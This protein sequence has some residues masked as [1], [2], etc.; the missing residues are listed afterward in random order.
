MPCVDVDVDE[1]AE[2]NGGCSPLA[3][4][5]NSPGTYACTC[6]PGYIGDGVNCTGKSGEVEMMMMKRDKC[7]TGH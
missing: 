6:L 3:N 5:T 1:C 4:C 7:I 2:N